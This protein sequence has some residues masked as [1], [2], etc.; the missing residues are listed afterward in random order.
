VRVV[1]LRHRGPDRR[2][3]PATA[4]SPGFARLVLAIRLHVDVLLRTDLRRTPA[5]ERAPR[6]SPRGA[7]G[8]SVLWTRA[9]AAGQASLSENDT[10]VYLS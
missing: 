2:V 8:C 6:L 10:R 7:P 1:E 9:A 5:Q 3:A 4:I